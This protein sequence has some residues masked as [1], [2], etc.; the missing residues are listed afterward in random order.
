MI[1]KTAIAAVILVFTGAACFIISNYLFSHNISSKGLQVVSSDKPISKLKEEPDIA[2]GDRLREIQAKA[3]TIWS[4]PPEDQQVVRSELPP[5]KDVS[6]LPVLEP[7]INDTGPMPI[8][9]DGAKKELP[10][11]KAELSSDGPVVPPGT[12]V[13]SLPPFTPT[14]NKTGPV[15]VDKKNG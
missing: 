8:G 12:S 4:K 15:P 7:V 5:E 6:P 2:W 10:E 3:D 14:T 1:K 9:S 13:E 11:F